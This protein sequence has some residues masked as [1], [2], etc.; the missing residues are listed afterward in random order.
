MN[1]QADRCMDGQLGMVKKLL[2]SVFTKTC[3]YNNKTS[4][5][6]PFYY[7]IPIYRYPD[8]HNSN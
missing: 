8:I 7:L 2:S 1:G 5:W 3:R 6:M 4:I